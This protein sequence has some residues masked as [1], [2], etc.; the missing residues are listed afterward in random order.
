[1]FYETSTK[2]NMETK[3]SDFRRAQIDLQQY[4]DLSVSNDIYRLARLPE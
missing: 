3:R 4:G 2:D 1:M